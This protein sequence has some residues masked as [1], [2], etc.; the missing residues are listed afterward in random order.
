MY[1]FDELNKMDNERLQEAANAIGIK[2][3]NLEDKE[4]SYMRFS[5]NRHVTM[6]PRPQPTLRV[7]TNRAGRKKNPRSR[8][9]NA[10]NA[11]KKPRRTL[12]RNL[13]RTITSL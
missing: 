10:S 7:R 6:P 5:K 11:A 4:V 12:R 1:N 2:K 3:I 13:P 8:P 9:A